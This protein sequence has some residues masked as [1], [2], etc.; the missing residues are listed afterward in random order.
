[1]EGFAD[2]VAR[3]RERLQAERDS[4]IQQRRDIDQKLATID[5]EFRAVD[6]YEA[7]K[8]GKNASAKGAGG[9]GRGRGTRRG[10]KREALLEVIRDNPSGL[11]RGEILERMGLKGDKAGEMS[12]SNAL[13]ALTKAN[14]VGREG[15]KYRLSA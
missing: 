1:M 8:A 5:K 14:Q 11:T 13:T 12:V 7:A 10:S 3:E 4:L 9:Q 6:A 15:G 2:Y